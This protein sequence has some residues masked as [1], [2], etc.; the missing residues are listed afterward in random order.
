MTRITT[1]A[2]D[3][4]DGLLAEHYGAGAVSAAMEAVLGANL[5]L[6]RLGPQPPAGTVIVLPDLPAAAP[7][8]R[9]WD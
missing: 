7:G 1:I 9:L 3:T 2:G 5:D 8:I 4:L 6:A